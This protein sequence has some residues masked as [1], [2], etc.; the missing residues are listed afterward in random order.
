MMNFRGNLYVGNNVISSR[1]FCK[2]SVHNNV[3]V[4]WELP[5]NN[6]ESKIMDFC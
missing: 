6:K 5:F 1:Q 4:Y 3:V 2:T